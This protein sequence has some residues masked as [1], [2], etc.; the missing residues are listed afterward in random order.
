MER[1]FY[2][3]HLRAYMAEKLAG[4]VQG[5]SDVQVV[6]EIARCVQALL[7]KTHGMETC[8]NHRRILKALHGGDTVISFNYDL[9]AERAI[10]SIAEQRDV[11]FGPFLYGSGEEP[12]GFHLPTILKLHGSSNWRV[13]TAGEEELIEVRTRRWADLDDKPGY[14]GHI[15]DGTV[16]PIFL[17]FWEKE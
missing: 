11:Q 3:L 7:R 12:P 9:V 2:T 14:R 8:Q 5:P 10:R 4:A 6:G 15:G 13:K 17:P 1:A 16:F